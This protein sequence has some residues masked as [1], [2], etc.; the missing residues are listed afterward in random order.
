MNEIE[1]LIRIEGDWAIY[2]I[3][4]RVWHG[5]QPAPVRVVKRRIHTEGEH[6]RHLPVEQIPERPTALQTVAEEAVDIVGG[7][8]D[9]TGL[10]LFRKSRGL[11]K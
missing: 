6:R 9:A 8:I 1:T 3:R 2:E 10:G 5:V 11:F 4:P 7:I